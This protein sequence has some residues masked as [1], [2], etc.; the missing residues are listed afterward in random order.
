LDSDGEPMTSVYLDHKGDAAMHT[1]K[2]RKLSARDDAILTSLGDAV[3]LHG[4]EPTTEIKAKFA[5]FDSFEGKVQK[6]V[7]VEQWRELAYKAI[8]VDCENED[9][10]PDAL[11]KAFKRCRDKLFNNGF[12]VEYNDYAW[13]LYE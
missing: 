7:L 5:G 11:K 13:R 2:R 12:T 4:V 9:K 8:V 10:K 3:T 6:I 1:T